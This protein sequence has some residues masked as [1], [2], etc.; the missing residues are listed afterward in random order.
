[1]SR[2]Y[3][4]VF[5]TS[6]HPK[7]FRG[8][9]ARDFRRLISSSLPSFRSLFLHPYGMLHTSFYD[10]I[11]FA[12]GGKI[13]QRLDVTS[14]ILNL[15]IFEEPIKNFEPLR[16]LKMLVGEGLKGLIES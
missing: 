13:I 11:D 8:H 16:I 7:F 12:D 4:L 10:Y 3:V 9:F 1:M 2:C 14:I 5:L 6:L 15:A